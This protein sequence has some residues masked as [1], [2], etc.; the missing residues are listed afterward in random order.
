M[1]LEYQPKNNYNKKKWTIEDFKKSFNEVN[2]TLNNQYVCSFE[3]YVNQSTL[4]T[5][6]CTKCGES[7]KRKP[8]VFLYQNSTCIY[9]NGSSRNR[10]YSTKEWVE[11]AKRI[12]NNKYDYSKS[13]YQT[14]DKK[15]C[16]ICHEVDEFGEEH[17]EFWVTP[18][19]HTGNMH[20]GCPRCAKKYS[21]TKR[22]IQ[23]AQRKYN[24]IYDY[25]KVIYK[26]AF[27][28]VSIICPEHGIFKITPNQHLSGKGCPK[29]NTSS[30]EKSIMHQLDKLN[31]NYIYQAKLKWLGTLTLD[32]FLPDYNIAIECQGEQ[33]FKYIPFFYKN[34]AKFQK[35]IERDKIKTKLCEENNVKLLYFTNLEKYQNKTNLFSFEEI[36][37]QLKHLKKE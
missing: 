23:L 11:L 4:I 7:F 25:S 13:E 29:C 28:K 18:H 14:T 35:A 1:S 2:Q 32:F 24:N 33:H 5:F 16:I 6:H 26:D 15:V 30:L 27:S 17:G 21:D 37:D 3:E 31:I 20:S 10:K 9:C 19:S 34:E 36:V 8:T 22:F 12:H